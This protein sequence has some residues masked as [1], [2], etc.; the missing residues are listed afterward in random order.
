MVTPKPWNYLEIKFLLV[1]LN[2]QVEEFTI[3]PYTQIIGFIF[4]DLDNS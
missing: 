1:H 4:F 3:E 2:F